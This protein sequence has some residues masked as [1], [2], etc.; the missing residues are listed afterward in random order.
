M[1][2]YTQPKFEFFELNQNVVMASATPYSAEGQDD[3][4]GNEGGFSL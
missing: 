2:S 4:F 3:P 1:K